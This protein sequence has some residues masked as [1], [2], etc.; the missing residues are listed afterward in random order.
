MNK[1]EVKQQEWEN[2]EFPILCEVCLGP[3][4]AL[5]MTRA[6]HGSECKTCSRPFTVFRWKPGKDARF[7]KTEICQ[8]CS[9][10]KNICQTCLLD[11]QYNLP[12][13]ARD[14]LLGEGD[15]GSFC[16]QDI[17]KLE[18]NRQFFFQTMR[19]R[20]ADQDTSG[21]DTSAP[22]LVGI[23]APIV[24]QKLLSIAKKRAATTNY[25]RNLPHVC[26][27]YAKKECNR[28]DACPFRHQLDAHDEQLS[29]QK[30]KDRYFGTRD[31]V[32]DK[33]IARENAA[34]KKEKIAKAIGDMGSNEEHPFANNAP[35][36]P[37]QNPNRLGS[38][39]HQ[40]GTNK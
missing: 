39:Y 32:A 19:T 5:R 20:L 34:A 38:T 15:A 2:S 16:S 7:K 37:S 25:R 1:S 31:P 27:F 40:K 17:P 12:V 4:E 13:K 6:V 35:K 33:I 9:R 28:G 8:I 30:I 10:V 23:D 36:Y 22:L 18:V 11:L 29:D 24:N 21:G 14:A 3:D 26:S